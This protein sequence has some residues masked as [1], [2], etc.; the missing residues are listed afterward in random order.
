MTK[1][2]TNGCKQQNNKNSYK[3]IFDV[4][5]IIM[6][7]VLIPTFVIISILFVIQPAFGDKFVL[8]EGT[9]NIAATIGG[10]STLIVG[11]ANVLVLYLAFK[12]QRDANDIQ[13]DIYNDNFNK[14]KAEIEALK[15]QQENLM[16]ETKMTNYK[17]LANDFNQLK[18]IYESQFVEKDNEKMSVHL[19]FSN[20][21]IVMKNCKKTNNAIVYFLT[22]FLQS[23]RYYLEEMKNANIHEIQKNNLSKKVND[24]IKGDFE[25]NVYKY[26]ND[27]WKE[28]HQVKPLYGEIEDLLR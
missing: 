20:I 4:V 14:H 18:L 8:N 15:L 11:T 19:N 5:I 28:T 24:F 25:N 2:L 10:M 16:E 26:L 27:E 17:Q 22:S 7:F 13:Q 21:V 3:R 12:I 9:A 6:I 1:N 23:L